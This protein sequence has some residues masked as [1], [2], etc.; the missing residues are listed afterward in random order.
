MSTFTTKDGTE[1]YFKDWGDGQPIVFNHAYCLNS[2]AF[3]DQMFFLASRGYR[4]IAHDRRGHGRSSQPWRGNDLDT[5]AEDLAELMEDLDLRDAVLV[6]H[7]TGGGVVARY[8][9]RYGTKRVAKAVLI[10]SATPSLLQTAEN[11]GGTPLEVFDGFRN[12]VLANRAQFMKDLAVIYFG[13]DIPEAKVSES[14]L[15]TSWNQEMLTGFPA[16]YF[17]IKA[18]SETD[19]TEDLKRIDVPTLILH[20]NVD[21]IVPIS[22]AYRSAKLIPNAEL[23]EYPGAPHAIIATDK[24][25]VNTDLLAFIEMPI[26]GQDAWAEVA[27]SRSSRFQDNALATPMPG[28]VSQS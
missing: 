6:G 22:N 13:A 16:A 15:D 27:H 19:T 2:D 21:R 25:Q 10:A 17:A 9:G 4:C 14:L 8:I 26:A 12:A 11:P 5:Y 20:G 3:E 1:L 24:D 28:G 23:K 7:S 18:F